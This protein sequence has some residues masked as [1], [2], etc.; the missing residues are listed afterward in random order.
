[1]RIVGVQHMVGE[2]EG[3]PFDN[4]RIYTVDQDRQNQETYGV[5]PMYTKV[6]ASVLHQVVAPDKINKL[7]DK[8]V[9]FYFDAYKNVVKVEFI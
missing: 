3:K 6:K 9:M 8:N 5:C 1:M 7:I 2:Y 4:Y